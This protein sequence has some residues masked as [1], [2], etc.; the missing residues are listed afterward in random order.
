MVVLADVYSQVALT[1]LVGAA[2]VVLVLPTVGQKMVATVARL[3]A[4]VV[5]HTDSQGVQEVGP[6]L[7][8]MLVERERLRVVQT[9]VVVEQEI[10]TVRMVVMAFVQE[11]AAEVD[12]Q[13]RQARMPRLQFMVAVVQVL[14]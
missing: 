11:V 9:T 10:L 4:V 7:V 14:I 8:R 1:V 13:E 2:V 6:V 12:A 3:V 5:A